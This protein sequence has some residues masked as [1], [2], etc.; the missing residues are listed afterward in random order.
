M[1]SLHHK[2]FDKGAFT[3]SAGRITLSECCYG[4]SGFEFPLLRYHGKPINAP[5]PSLYSTLAEYFKWHEKEAFKRQTR[6]W[7]RE[8]SEN[9]G[10]AS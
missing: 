4:N 5:V 3:V 6:E 9:K 10:V 2:L 8:L 1:Y 7:P